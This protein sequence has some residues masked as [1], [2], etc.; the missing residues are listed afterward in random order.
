MIKKLII[1]SILVIACADLSAWHARGHMLVA[2]IA[3]DH[4]DEA[5]RKN[6]V[7]ILQSHP[8]FA[9]NWQEQYADHEDDVTLGKFLMMQA[10]VWPDQIKRRNHPDFRYNRASWHYITYEMRKAAGDSGTISTNTNLEVN[11]KGDVLTAIERARWMMARPSTSKEEKAVYLCWLIHLIGDIHQP[12]H[13]ASLFNDTD[14]QKGDKGGNMIYI[15]PNSVGIKLHTFWDGLPGS[16]KNI[17]TTANTAKVLS[18]KNPKS[19]FGLLVVND[20]R[21]WS[22]ESLNLAAKIVHLDGQLIVTTDKECA[23]KPPESYSKNSK[24]IALRLV[25]LAG[26]RLALDVDNLVN[27]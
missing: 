16:S 8:E 22:Y 20:S 6:V 1:F 13:C 17:R 25:V 24:R 23:V 18:R 12:L 5:S 3:W 27:L 21:K 9:R 11:K 2:A 4:L 15:K 7:E 19:G 26:Y 10:S 14:L